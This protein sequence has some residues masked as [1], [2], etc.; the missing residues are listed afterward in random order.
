MDKEDKEKREENELEKLRTHPGYQFKLYDG[1][2]RHLHRGD[3]E[4]FLRCGRDLLFTTDGLSD[5]RIL[6]AKCEITDRAVVLY[7]D[8]DYFELEYRCGDWHRHLHGWQFA[9]DCRGMSVADVEYMMARYLVRAQ[10]DRRMSKASVLRSE[11]KDFW[12]EGEDPKVVREIEDSMSKDW[13]V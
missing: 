1:G 7:V 9:A 11:R 8:R 6:L 13:L 12:E 5:D 10:T 4:R 2:F 3:A